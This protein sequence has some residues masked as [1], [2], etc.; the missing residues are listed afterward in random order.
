MYYSEGTGFWVLRG[1]ARDPP[2]GD[3]WHKLCFESYDSKSTSYLTNAGTISTLRVQPSQSPYWA[4]FLLPDIY[5][6]RDIATRERP[7]GLV[8]D[9]PIFLGLMAFT[10]TREKIAG[11]LPCAFSNGNWKLHSW[12]EARTH[13]RGI[14]V[15]VYASTTPGST[16]TDLYHY[17]MGSH[18]Q[19]F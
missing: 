14:V 10:T 4:H 18:G 2:A 9:L 12:P 3:E 13:K 11:V 19:Y 5:H 17:E 16:R 1:D 15:T 7:G 8:G 6:T